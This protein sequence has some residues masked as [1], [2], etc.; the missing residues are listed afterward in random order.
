MYVRRSIGCGTPVSCSKLRIR[1]LHHTS[2]SW[3][4]ISKREDLR[5]DSTRLCQT[6]IMRQPEYH[7]EV[8]LVRCFT[9]CTATTCHGRTLVYP[10]RQCWSHLLTTCVSPTGPSP[11][12][13]QHLRNGQDVGTM[14]SM[15]TN[16]QMCATHWKWEH[17]RLCSL[18]AP[19]SPSP[20]QPNILV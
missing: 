5:Y 15:V 9:A 12:S 16:Q 3:G 14:S 4:R 10:G 8:Y 6:S 17:H 20:I 13:H 2:D 7:K 18:M 1:V 19:L 11:T